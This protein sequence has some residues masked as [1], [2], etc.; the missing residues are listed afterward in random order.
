MSIEVF[1]NRPARPFPLNRLLADIAGAQKTLAVASAWFTLRP[2]VDAI[3]Q[4]RADEKYVVLNGADLGRGGGAGQR[5]LEILEAAA[6]RRWEESHAWEKF[7]V[8]IIG[9][10]DFK[11]GIMHH[12][13]V[14]IDGR[15]LWTGSYNLTYQASKNYEALLRIEEDP[16]TVEH[17]TAAQQFENEAF[18]MVFSEPNLWEGSTSEA[19]SEDAFRCYVCKRIFQFELAVDW[20]EPDGHVTCTKCAG[21]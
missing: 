11:D 4:S 18:T 16:S 20:W 1:F 17:E 15:I 7:A 14:S 13:F 12:K 5:I 6:Q 8:K 10:A 19:S 3:V 21:K 9:S 2:L